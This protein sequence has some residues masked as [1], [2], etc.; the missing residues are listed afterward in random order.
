MRRILLVD[1]DSNFLELARLGLEENVGAEVVCATGVTEAVYQLNRG[2]KFDLIISE[3]ILTDGTGL[4]LLRFQISQSSS[5][6]FLFFTHASR[7]EI[8]YTSTG[9][10]GVFGKN[11]FDQ[12][13]S[14][15]K[16]ILGKTKHE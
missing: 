1:S 10:I 12:L 3:Y 14:S 8:P 9:F 11:E 6:P 16:L 13:C 7:L 4:D 2:N 15:V 5:I